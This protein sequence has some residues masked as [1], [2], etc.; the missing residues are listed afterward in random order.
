M[1]PEIIKFCC[2]HLAKINLALMAEQHY[3]VTQQYG[4]ITA[5]RQSNP[6]NRSTNR[7]MNYESKINVKKQEIITSIAFAV[8][9]SRGI[10]VTE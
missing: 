9:E 3:R 5:I 6:P 1:Q 7:H 10:N 4:G 8:E 2:V